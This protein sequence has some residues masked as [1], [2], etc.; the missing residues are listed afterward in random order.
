MADKSDVD[1]AT[2]RTRVTS[3]GGTTEQAIRSFQQANFEKLV[4]NALKA[5][6]DRSQT[7]A[8]ELSK[9]PS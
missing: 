4:E 2:L 3:K 7:L 9:D 8:D 6:S 1:V 5:A